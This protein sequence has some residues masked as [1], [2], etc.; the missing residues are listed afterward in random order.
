MNVHVVNR[1]QSLEDMIKHQELEPQ[2]IAESGVARMLYAEANVKG[3]P[4][5]LV[6]LSFEED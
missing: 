3:R 2:D 1:L 6:M 5:P 4:G